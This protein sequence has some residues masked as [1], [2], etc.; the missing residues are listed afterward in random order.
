MDIKELK[1]KAYEIR[2]KI[3]YL[4]YQKQQLAT[5][6]IAL[7]NEIAKLEKDKNV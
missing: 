1:A 2:V 4:D 5:E 3:D 7:V 6:Y